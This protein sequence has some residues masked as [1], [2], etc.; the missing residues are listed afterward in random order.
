MNSCRHYTDEAERR[1]RQRFQG[2][3][4]LLD[5]LDTLKNALAGG[6]EIRQWLTDLF[7]K[8]QAELSHAL[9]QDQLRYFSEL[10]QRSQELGGQM[11]EVLESPPTTSANPPPTRCRADERRPLT[12][13]AGDCCSLV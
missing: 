3:H 11:L 9:Y 4:S 12:R 5:A 7:A 10:R 1:L 6:H 13:S 8:V 2:R